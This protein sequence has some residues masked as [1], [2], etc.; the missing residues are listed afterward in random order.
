MVALLHKLTS[1][2]P[3]HHTNPYLPSLAAVTNQWLVQTAMATHL[4]QWLLC[5]SPA[6]DTSDGSSSTGEN[7]PELK[8]GQTIQELWLQLR[9]MVCG[10]S[11]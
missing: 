11:K 6:M 1:H 9:Q 2:S 10:A 8:V 5:C 7:S 3:E 4:A